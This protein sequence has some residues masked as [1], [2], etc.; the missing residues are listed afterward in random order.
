[1]KLFRP[2]LRPALLL[3]LLSQAF[4]VVATP[5]P[6]VTIG[7]NFSGNSDNNNP[8][9]T[10]P[11]CDGVVGPRYFVEF[12]N[13]SFYVYNKTNTTV[14]VRISDATFW[15][16]AGVTLSSSDGLSDPRILYDAASQRWFASQ[17]AFDANALDPSLE[18]DDFLLGVS[19]GSDPTGTWHAFRFQADPDTGY[20]ADFPTLGLD[21]SGVYLSGDLYFG[22]DNPIGPA[23]VSIPKSDLLAPAP[24]ITNRTWFGVL[25]YAQRGQILQPAVCFDGSVSGRILAASDIGNDSL[26]HSNLVSFAVQNPGAL[27]A[28][29]SDPALIPTPSWEVPDNPYLMVPYFSV[30]QPDNTD[31]L[32]G[33][34]ARLSAYVYAVGGAL[35]AAQSTEFNGHVAIRWYRARAADNTLLESGT[36]SD[37]S[38]DLIFPSIAANAFG[39]VVIG[40]NGCGTGSYLSSY[41]MV[42][43]TVNG[44]TTFG[45]RLLLTTSS[46]SYHDFQES[47]TLAEISRWGDYSSTSVDPSDP[48][49]FWT[50]QLFP[51]YSATWDCGIWNTQITELIT[52]PAPVLAIQPSGTNMLVS[53]PTAFTGYRLTYATNLLNSIS[54]LNVSQSQQTNGNQLVVQIPKATSPQFFRLQKP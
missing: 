10:P 38:L 17:V 48:N 29:L 32:V 40:F 6:S 11:D 12:L 4:G 20:F 23:L 45:N 52:T 37:P 51:T 49:R 8:L 2:D 25:D 16:R 30:H 9:I 41:A 15:S 7:R 5:V 43:Q 50:M 47:S 34:E 42:G 46:T 39:V 13:G 54:W 18:S 31:T 33:N 19:A 35:Y 53:W 44:T 28:S 27:G 14:P 22:M 24:T 26:P 36:I 1:M 21:A 3:L